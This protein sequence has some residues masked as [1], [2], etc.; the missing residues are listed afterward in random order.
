MNVFQEN[1]IK[2]KNMYISNLFKQI[3]GDLFNIEKVYLTTYLEKKKREN[4]NQLN[5]QKIITTNVLL[6]KQS[7]KPLRMAT[8]LL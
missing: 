2:T 7:Y 5:I 6:I 3:F 4:H 8:Y 1:H